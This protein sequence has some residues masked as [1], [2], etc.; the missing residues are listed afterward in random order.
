MTHN[1]SKVQKTSNA[2][3]WGYHKETKQFMALTAED[4][5]WQYKFPDE[6]LECETLLATYLKQEK[7]ILQSGIS[8]N[9]N[10][11]P[12]KTSLDQVI[13][14]NT[15]SFRRLWNGREISPAAAIENGKVQQQ[16]KELLFKH[17]LELAKKNAQLQKSIQV[18]FICV[19]S[20]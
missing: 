19:L 15:P 2:T 8:V 18:P 12:F 11:K 10:K 16:I 9:K 4:I 1:Y 3:R 17:N 13:F 20:L 7:F 14:L 5:S 6:I